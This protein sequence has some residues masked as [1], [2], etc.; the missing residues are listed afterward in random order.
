MKNGNGTFIVKFP[1][2]LIHSCCMAIK[3]CK[4]CRNILVCYSVKFLV[5]KYIAYFWS[6]FSA[7]LLTLQQYFYTKTVMNVMRVMYLKLTLKV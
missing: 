2:Q 7:R 3:N 5:N 1:A 4:T 6:N